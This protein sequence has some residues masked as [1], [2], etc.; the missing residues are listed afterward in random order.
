MCMTINKMTFFT[1]G[2][3]VK[4]NTIRGGLANQAF[5]LTPS[6]PLGPT[7]LGR[8]QEEVKGDCAEFSF[9]LW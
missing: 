8:P 3:K 5:G 1:H 9:G 6:G 2:I 7:W 4:V